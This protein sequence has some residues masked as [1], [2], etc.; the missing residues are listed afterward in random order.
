MGGAF[1]AAAEGQRHQTKQLDCQIRFG[2]PREIRV[3]FSWW[4]G[5]DRLWPKACWDWQ[6]PTLKIV[7]NACSGGYSARCRVI[8]W[9]NSQ[10]LSGWLAGGPLKTK[11]WHCV[12]EL[13]GSPDSVALPRQPGSP[14]SMLHLE[15]TWTYGYGSARGAGE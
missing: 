15:R 10:A 13:A 7:V 14:P 12:G 8:C 6:V 1:G 3:G 2:Q 9:G 5:R 4:L 11:L